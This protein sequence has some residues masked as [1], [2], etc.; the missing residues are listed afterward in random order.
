MKMGD[1]VQKRDKATGRIFRLK[2]GWM[3]I[4]GNVHSPLQRVMVLDMLM[5]DPDLCDF[6]YVLTHLGP[7][8]MYVDDL[9]EE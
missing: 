8:Y 5:N 4:I 3:H 6:V 1:L 7:A 9:E 2:N